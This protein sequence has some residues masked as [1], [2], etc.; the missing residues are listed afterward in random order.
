MAS[1]QTVLKR[2]RSRVMR[3][4]K[5]RK[6]DY[7]MRAY[8]RQKAKMGIWDNRFLNGNAGDINISTKRFIMRG[9]LAGLICTS[10]TGGKHA[11]TSY[12]YR[13]MA[14]D[15]GHAKPG[16]VEAVNALTKFQRAEYT[17]QP[18]RYYELFGP[19]NYANVKNGNH[20]TLPEGSPLEELH[21]NHVHGACRF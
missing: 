9:Y 20:L 8:L 12:H 19:D 2:L 4:P 11:P 21:D 6:R 13:H 14:A 10:T 17:K 3:A 1:Q 5:G 7:W 15:L 16:S 18:G